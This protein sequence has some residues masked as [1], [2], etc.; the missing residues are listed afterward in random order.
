MAKTSKETTAVGRRGFLKGAPAGAAALVVK[1][2]LAEVPLS[3]ADLVR[4]LRVRLMPM[5]LQSTKSK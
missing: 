5:G 4:N 1:T 2:S 3:H